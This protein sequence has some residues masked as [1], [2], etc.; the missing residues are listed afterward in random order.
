MLFSC[1]S[2]ISYYMIS[3]AI[4]FKQA[5]VNFLKD[6]KLHLPYGLMWF[7]CPW[8]I[9]SCLL[10]PNCIR[11]QIVIYTE[12]R[13]NALNL[14]ECIG[15]QR[16]TYFALACCLVCASPNALKWKSMH[17]LLDV[18]DR[19]AQFFHVYWCTEARCVGVPWRKWG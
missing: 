7:C 5:L 10:T 1:K 6:Y 18:G 12:Y 14:V 3:R 4:W 15:F 17:C 19:I 16:R 11:N 13:K 2:L 9:Y 8:K